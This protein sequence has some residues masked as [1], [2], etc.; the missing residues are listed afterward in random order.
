MAVVQFSGERAV[1]VAV[2]AGGESVTAVSPAGDSVVA[3][4]RRR[5][6]RRVHLAHELSRRERG[7][8]ASCAVEAEDHWDDGARAQLA[9]VGFTYRS[10]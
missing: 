10:S 7:R 3:A 9:M 4:V 2:S 5:R 8:A 6:L 1:L